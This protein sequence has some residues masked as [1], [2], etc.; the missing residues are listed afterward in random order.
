MTE[1]EAKKVIQLIAAEYP[2][3][4]KGMERVQMQSK[5]ALWAELFEDT[6]VEAVLAAV[7]TYIATDTS[8][9]GPKIGQL[10]DII[11]RASE[12][13]NPAGMLSEADAVKA[14]RKAVANSGY[15]ADEEFD[16]LP[17]P[18]KDIVGSPMA[19]RSYGL[20]EASEF[21]GI[22]LSQFR[23]QYRE[24]LTGY[25]EEA[26][27]PGRTEAAL[28]ESVKQLLGDREMREDFIARLGKGAD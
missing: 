15:H 13:C 5:A 9:F 16:R 14:L 6:P 12:K 4:Y 27:M 7:K 25:R 10:R 18:V 26:K 1:I 24:S 17:D 20:M 22:I 3:E 23:R 8:G 28:A 21:E 19:L 2:N 11:F